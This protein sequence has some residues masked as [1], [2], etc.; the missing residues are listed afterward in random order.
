MDNM[1]KTFYTERDVEVLIAQGVKSLIVDEDVVLTDLAYEK[2]QKVGLELLRQDDKPPAAPVRPYIAAK[3]STADRRPAP[4]ADQP[5]APP[6]EATAAD[7]VEEIDL[8][9]RVYQAAL[10]RLGDAV[11]PKL[12]DTIVGRV[13]KSI[14]TK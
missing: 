13:L 11:D 4:V 2:A 1:P 7:V 5:Q 6:Q 3:P 12:L 9:Q 8:H 10:A 14:H